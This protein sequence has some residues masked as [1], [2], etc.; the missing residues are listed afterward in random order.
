MNVKR[1]GVYNTTR[2]DLYGRDIMATYECR[3]CGTKVVVTETGG[4]N[5]QPIYCCGMEVS[6]V[7][8]VRSELVTKARK[9]GGKKKRGI[10]GKTAGRAGQQ[11]RV[12]GGKA[13]PRKRVSKSTKKK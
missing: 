5:L 10:P 3:K 9:S 6:R 4:T 8:A 7:A 1:Y 12:S 2:C 11:K 13:S